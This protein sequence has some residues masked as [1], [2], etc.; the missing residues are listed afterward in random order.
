M[1]SAFELK[2][3]FVMKDH[4]GKRALLQQFISLVKIIFCLM[5]YFEMHVLKSHILFTVSNL[6]FI[7]CQDIQ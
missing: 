3:C 2:M 5:Q 4:K 1:F 6:M 7:N